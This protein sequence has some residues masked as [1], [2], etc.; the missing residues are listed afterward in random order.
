MIIDGKILKEKVLEE[1]KE[2][3]K[4]I[5]KKLSLVVIQV[6]NDPASDVY[7]KQKE[8][9]A[10]T[11]GYNFKHIKLTEDIK[12]SVVINEIINLNN[13]DSVDG[14]LLQ[15]PLPRGLNE[16]KIINYIASEKDVD[17]LT[18]ANAGKLIHNKECLIPCTPLGISKILEEYNIEVSGKNVVIVGRSSLVGKPMASLLLNKNATVT[19]CHSKTNNLEEYTK[20][21]DIL[22]VAVGKKHL[23][24]KDMVK[25]DSVIIDVGINRVDGKLYG[26]VDFENVKDKV[27]YITPVPGGVGQMTVASLGENLLNAYLLRK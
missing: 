2:K 4:K 26:D 3:T 12:E 9:M 13:D 22:I 1:L 20:L 14:I 10:I 24:T 6:G 23:I 17:G 16:N 19:V 27:S 11:V 25:K 21:A 7:V 18:D 8:K 5:A 15:L